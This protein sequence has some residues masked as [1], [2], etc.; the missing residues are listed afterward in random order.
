MTTAGLVSD[1]NLP[2]DLLDGFD[3]ES[4]HTRHTNP[5][6]GVSGQEVSSV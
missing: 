2:F 1:D 5:Y 6:F 3:A 4:R